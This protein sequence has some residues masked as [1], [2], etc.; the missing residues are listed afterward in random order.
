VEIHSLN[1]PHTN[2]TQM[3]ALKHFYAKLADPRYPV[4]GGVATC[5]VVFNGYVAHYPVFVGDGRGHECAVVG[6]NAQIHRA[7]A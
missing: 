4:V 6:V 2:S 3:S 1:I 5:A 7:F